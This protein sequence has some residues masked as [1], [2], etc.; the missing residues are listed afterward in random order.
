M[1]ANQLNN[2]RLK[3]IEKIAPATTKTIN[4]RYK[5]PWDDEDLK[6]PKK[7]HGKQNKE[8]D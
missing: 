8:M 6:N 5:K 3:T 7:D 4:S 2:E 1:A